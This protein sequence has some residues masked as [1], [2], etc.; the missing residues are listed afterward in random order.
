LHWVAEDPNHD[1]SDLPDW[2][3]KEVETA[4]ALLANDGTRFIDPPHRLGG[5][6]LDFSESQ[7]D[8]SCSGM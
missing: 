6:D 7:V 3:R 1:G 4:R 2:H 8:M 5:L